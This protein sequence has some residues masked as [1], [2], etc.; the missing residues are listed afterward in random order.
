M[1]HRGV[2][3]PN[4]TILVFGLFSLVVVVLLFGLYRDVNVSPPNASNDLMGFAVHPL[5]NS[6][7][8]PESG[9]T[10]NNNSIRL[11][12]TVLMAPHGKVLIYPERYTIVTIT[13]YGSTV[14][15]QGH[16]QILVVENTT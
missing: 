10:F 6:F 4:R 2:V 3:S 7:S 11:D 1:N 5:H 13:L 12:T 15:H 16:Y 9:F 14:L 8:T